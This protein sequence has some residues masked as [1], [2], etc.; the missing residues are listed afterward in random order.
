MSDLKFN[1]NDSVKVK[2]T[3][4]GIEHYVKNHNSLLPF[5]YQ[6]SFNEYKSRADKDGYH[7]YQMHQFLDSFGG[8]GMNIASLINLNILIP[9]HTLT[10]SE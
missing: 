3:D 9:E 2:L 6:L 10:K 1:L 5:Q 8:V 7:Y 4:A